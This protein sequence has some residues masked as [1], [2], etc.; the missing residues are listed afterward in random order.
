VTAA[1]PRIGAGGR[2]IYVG[3][4]TSGRLGVLDGVELQS[5]V[6]LATHERALSVLAGG[7]GAMF[8]AVE[9]AED[10]ARR[11]APPT[12]RRCKSRA[13]RRGDAAG[14]VGRHALRA[15]RAGRGPRQ[16]RADHRHRQQCRARQ[17]VLRRRDSGSRWTPAPRSS[18][19]ARG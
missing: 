5:D 16:R 4:G 14:R 18:P 13:E 10:D 7:K 8:Q 1:A 9:G 6:F 3:A 12:W 17:L 15:G 11:K 2:L 19:A